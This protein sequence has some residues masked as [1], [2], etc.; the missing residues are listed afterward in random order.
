MSY[1]HQIKTN[2]FQTNYQAMSQW[3]AKEPN[4]RLKSQM[5]Y[6]IPEK[7]TRASK[8]SIL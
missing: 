2:Q 7:K 3:G 4:Q 5:D 6:I 1:H 8:R